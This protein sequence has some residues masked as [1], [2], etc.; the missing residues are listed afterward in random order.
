MAAC[1]RCG[2]PFSGPPP[3]DGWYRCPFCEALTDARAAPEPVRPEPPTEPTRE[4]AREAPARARAVAADAT[5]ASSG[6][7][8]TI[9]ILL[10][11]AAG[12][13]GILLYVNLHRSV[14]SVVGPTVCVADVNGGPRDVI[15]SGY[16]V[17]D[18]THRVIALDGDDG[19]MLWRSEPMADGQAF[20]CGGGRRALVAGPGFAVTALDVR[21]GETAWTERLG[22]RLGQVSVA[23][24][25]R[26]ARASLVD[27][28][29][30]SFD[31][32]TGR[33]TE[34]PDAPPVPRHAAEARDAVKATWSRAQAN[35]V[36]YS[37]SARER[38][39]PMLAVTATRSDGALLWT[40]ELSAHAFPHE[41]EVPAYITMAGSQLIVV[42]ADP[43]HTDRVAFLA[44]DPGSGRERARYVVSEDDASGFGAGNVDWIHL[45]GGILMVHAFATV[46]A[47]D[48]ATLDERWRVGW[49]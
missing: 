30:V 7:G 41:R 42:G 24:G 5:T 8:C 23:P 9:A 45:E 47:V 20:R 40:T 22:D 26:C 14:S 18:E 33:P 1:V 16:F 48:V 15:A 34:C 11:I 29:Q 32:D 43:N 36:V 3:E 25:D 6:I 31:L 39:T 13:G 49:N 21:T 37:V 38:G 46:V 28:S 10:A 35:G 19:D 27:G 2:A 4:P 12:I 17:N 44:L